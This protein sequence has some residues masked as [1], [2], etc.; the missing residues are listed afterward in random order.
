MDKKILFFKTFNKDLENLPIN[1][2][3]NLIL[4][5]KFK[6]RIIKESDF[7]HKY[8]NFNIEFYQSSYQDLKGLQFYD[9][10]RHYHFH[11]RLEKR[12]CNENI[13]YFKLDGLTEYNIDKILLKYLDL[14]DKSI[15]EIYHK[16][17]NIFYWNE[18]KKNIIKFK[19]FDI[20]FYG[21][22]YGIGK[23]KIIKHYIKNNTIKNNNIKNNTIITNKEVF[24]QQFTDYN[25]AS[26]ILLNNEL[27]E[28][29]LAKM[30][31][32]NN[33]INLMRIYNYFIENSFDFLKDYTDFFKKYNISRDYFNIFNPEFKAIHDSEFLNL[34]NT[35]DKNDLIFSNNDFKKKYP[36]FSLDIFN[37]FNLDY[38]N[39]EKE[40]YHLNYNTTR[41]IGCLEDFYFA[42][43]E[44]NDN[45]IQSI[46]EL[47]KY[48]KKKIGEIDLDLDEL[49]E[50]YPDFDQ[51]FY[52]SV[53]SDL[54]YYNKYDSI[55]HWHYHG[56]NE[57]RVY[58]IDNYLKKKKKL[59]Y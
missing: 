48:H 35:R 40:N 16:N 4:N 29:E 25:T 21:G 24:Y 41:L 28:S 7:F 49:M 59:S 39:V 15:V 36:L 33:E 56:K 46:D 37:K 8:P 47:I 26:F 51:I 19:D 58:Q 23:N 27:I 50:I 42:Y 45:K 9:I 44:C 54:R 6:N 20:N 17:I 2:I 1:T 55:R 11:G 13:F 38:K 12:F 57:G 18:L 3:Q 22:V 53:Y 5:K 52:T 32:I 43:P 10:L 30:N 34:Y 31:I 14:D